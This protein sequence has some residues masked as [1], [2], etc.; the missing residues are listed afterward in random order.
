LPSV[1][2][3]YSATSPGRASWFRVRHCHRGGGGDV[4]VD[5]DVLAG[6]FEGDL[7]DEV[8]TVDAGA[9]LDGDVVLVGDEGEFGPFAGVGG[10][11]GEGRK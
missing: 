6:G 8:G 1:S 11:G 7:D 2:D 9:V 3:R 5:V 4:E 10:E